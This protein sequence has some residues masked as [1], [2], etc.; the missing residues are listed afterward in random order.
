MRADAL[1][2]PECKASLPCAL[3]HYLP[4]QGISV[5]IFFVIQRL[6]S[7]VKLLCKCLLLSY[8]E[9]IKGKVETQRVCGHTTCQRRGFQYF[10][11]YLFDFIALH[12]T[13][14]FLVVF[15]VL[16]L[17]EFFEKS[18]FVSNVAAAARNFLTC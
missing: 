5:C 9:S 12:F 16:I 17:E 15:E 13:R 2:L 8:R 7:I 14:R 18:L 1:D 3:T 4:A 11:I 10:K 6:I